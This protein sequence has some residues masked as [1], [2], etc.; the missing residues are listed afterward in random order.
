M[1]TTVTIETGKEHSEAEKPR[2]YTIIR[3][4]KYK[5]GSGFS[6]QS[7]RFYEKE[8]AK[9]RLE[10]IIKKELAHILEKDEL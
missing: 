10:K 9:E 2:K 5:Y 8:T 4:E 6:A 1:K 3:V 7:F